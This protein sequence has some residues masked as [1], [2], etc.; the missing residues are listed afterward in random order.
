[1]AIDIFSRLP[2]DPE[3]EWEFFQQTEK[4]QCLIHPIWKHMAKLEESFLPSVVREKRHGYYT[5][6]EENWQKSTKLKEESIAALARN[7]LHLAA[8]LI[9]EGLQ[10]NPHDNQLYQ[11][12]DQILLTQKKYPDA[13]D[14]FQKEHLRIN[15]NPLE[16]Q[17]KLVDYFVINKRYQEALQNLVVLQQ[18]HQHAKF[19][20]YP[21]C[22]LYNRLGESKKALDHLAQAIYFDQ[23]VKE[24]ARKNPELANLQKEAEFRE[25]I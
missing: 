7:R 10:I 6:L 19:L 17:L 21:L 14:F 1:M 2:I 13:L 4:H 3:K 15:L 8:N 25:L 23:R 11:L 12:Y 9:L 18:K 16:A 20:H 5:T 22:V 24:L